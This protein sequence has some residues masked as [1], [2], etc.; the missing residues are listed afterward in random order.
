MQWHTVLPVDPFW[1]TT[2]KIIR[3]DRPCMLIKHTVAMSATGIH[4][5]KAVRLYV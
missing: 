3:G 2:E 1:R 5:I 4:F